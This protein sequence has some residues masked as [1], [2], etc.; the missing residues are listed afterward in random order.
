MREEC[1]I[2]DLSLSMDD[3][4]H[5][6]TCEITYLR[7][8]LA[9]SRE[10]N[11]WLKA[12]LTGAGTSRSA[13]VFRLLQSGR[14][15]LM[16]RSSRRE[17]L[18]IVGFDAIAWLARN[19]KHLFRAL[20]TK[21]PADCGGDRAA[22][23]GHAR[24]EIAALPSRRPPSNVLAIAQRTPPSGGTSVGKSS[25][26]DNLP[27]TGTL[28]P[29]ATIPYS[30]RSWQLLDTPASGCDSINLAIVS[31]LH[32]S[33]STLLQRICNARRKTL[34]WGEHNAMLSKFTDI[35]RGVAWFSIAGSKER[36]DYFKANENPNMWIADMCPELEYVEEAVV[37]SAQALLDTLYGQYRE[38]HDVV[39]FKEVQ[40]GRAEV[41]LLRRCCPKSQILLLVRHPCSTWNS[42]PRD[43]YSS[44][45]EWKTLWNHRAHEF[46]RLADSDPNCHLIRYEDIV[47]QEARAM[48][49][50]MDVAQVT[51]E[52]ISGVLAHKIGSNHVG[53][54]PAER[55]AI[56]ASCGDAM[57]L[58]GYGKE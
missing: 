19:I 23:V 48:E 49:I 51:R 11:E 20:V 43:W 54:S 6:T 31:L 39:G 36:E 16:P 40:Y 5:E 35:Y 21:S 38:W 9:H 42:T 4:R 29:L 33:G 50:I 45:A 24:E 30:P 34:L 41:E 25:S 52:E 10:Q 17:R 26:G 56:L 46:A 37:N 2:D 47:R 44:F 28:S 22:I 3:E 13:R 14:A 18:G 27:N 55:Q 53:I 15:S 58:L 1:L 12:Q 8:R 7:S 32:R 57:E